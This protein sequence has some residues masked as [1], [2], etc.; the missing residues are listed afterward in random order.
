MSYRRGQ[1]RLSRDVAFISGLMARKVPFITV[2]LGSDVD[3]FMPHLYVALAE[4]D[5]RYIAARTKDALGSQGQRHDPRQ[6]SAD[7]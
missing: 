1:A 7:Q 4:K 6:L 3:P 2:E 5:R